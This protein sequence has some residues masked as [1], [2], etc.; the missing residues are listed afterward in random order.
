[1]EKKFYQT[2][3]FKVGIGLFLGILLY[4]IVTGIFFK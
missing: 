1:M 2:E 4:K 3:S